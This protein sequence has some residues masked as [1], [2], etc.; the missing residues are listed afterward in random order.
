MSRVHIT[1][2]RYADSFELVYERRID[3]PLLKNFYTSYS[4]PPA[5]DYHLDVLIFVGGLSFCWRMQFLR[6]L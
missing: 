3:N 4:S 6:A 1:M 2:T 5:T